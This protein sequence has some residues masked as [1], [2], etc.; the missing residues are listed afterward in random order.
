MTRNTV[1]IGLQLYSLRDLSSR[2]LFLSLEKA[3]EQGYSFVEFAGFFGKS[4]EEVRNRLEALGLK[5]SGTHTG[6]PL[7]E[8]D[9]LEETLRF[10][11]TIGCDTVVIPWAEMKTDDRLDALIKRINELERLL[12]PLG[13]T[14]AYH[15]HSHEFV[16]T[17]SGAIP[18]EQLI[19]RT[20]IRLELD[21]YW[22]FAAGK[23][24][25]AL[26]K[27]LGDRVTAIHIKD[28]TPDGHGMPLGM[29]SAPVAAVYAEAKARGLPIIV[30]S[31][32]QT[33]DGPTETGICIQYLKK[34]E[35][36]L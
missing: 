15:N 16:P 32:T 8:A 10:H 17:P 11:R 29:G 3:K 35:G 19:A 4:A 6:L 23:D 31:E 9:T 24:P 28:G 30:E 26:L 33:P 22:A 25:V 36:S 5:V 14:L 12:T 21:T 20:D 34:L 2:D 27:R 1:P 18:Y 13:F 7:L